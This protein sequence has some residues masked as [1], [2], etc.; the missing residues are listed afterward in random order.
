MEQQAKQL[1]AIF[2]GELHQF[3]LPSGRVVTTR[4]PNGDDEEILSKKSLTAS[5]DNILI[6]MAS[7]IVEDSIDGKNPTKDKIAAW[8]TRDKYYFLLM[9]RIL[10][11][12]HDLIFKYAFQNDD[13]NTMV[14]IQEDLR[15]FTLPDYIWKE[16]KADPNNEDQMMEVVVDVKR[17]A[18]ACKSYIDE[19]ASMVEFEIDGLKFRFKHLDT[20]L[21]SVALASTEEVTKN[22]KLRDR[23]LEVLENNLWRPVTYFKQF[24]SKQV[25]QMRKKVLELD[26]EFSPQFIIASTNGNYK[27]IIDVF[28]VPTFYYPEEMM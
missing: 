3:A 9:Q 28:T 2:E 10:T 26:A 1:P 15:I 14:E 23:H 11:Y 18:S 22:S 25:A 13:T 12:G 27:D 17:H 19:N 4:E 5:G 8:K 20:N 6:Y 16:Q 21:E 7:I 24:S